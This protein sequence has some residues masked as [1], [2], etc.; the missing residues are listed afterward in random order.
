MNP[1]VFKILF[2]TFGLGLGN[3][4][5]ARPSHDDVD[6]RQARQE[7]RIEHGI[8]SG[9]LTRHEVRRLMRQQRKICDLEQ[10]VEADG[11]LSRHERRMLHEKLDRASDRIYRLKHNDRRRYARHDHDRDPRYRPYSRYDSSWW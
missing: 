2:I 10:A 6:R 3:Q 8:E 9:E 1:S 11:H 4:V 7:R 5:L